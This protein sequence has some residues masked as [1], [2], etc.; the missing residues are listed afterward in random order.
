MFELVKS[1]TIF[2]DSRKRRGSDTAYCY[3]VSFTADAANCSEDEVFRLTLKGL[4]TQLSWG[5][6]T[7]NTCSFTIKEDGVPRTVLILP[8]NYT[9]KSLAQAITTAYFAH[10]QS[11]VDHNRFRCT[12]SPVTN[13]LTFASA[14]GRALSLTFP[15]VAAAETYG[16]KS[17]TPGVLTSQQILNPMAHN[18]LCISVGGIRPRSTYNLA[19]VHSELVGRTNLMAVVPVD[20]TVPPYS[21][22]QWTNPGD[23]FTLYIT[24]RSLDTLQIQI[25]DW[26][27]N[28]F[29]AM[30]EHALTLQLD[31]FRCVDLKHQ[32][33]QSIDDRMQTL[34]LQNALQG[35]SSK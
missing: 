14:A 20:S 11:A 18:S 28:P 22:L 16:F 25:T 12:W 34:V 5:Y 27:G 35:P 7:V 24:E 33:L 23:L 1:Q 26:S 3:T 9:F 4:T 32:A 21:I 6:I 13:R 31:T 10:D 17:V 15:S 19:N 29:T 30:P 8:G 2:L